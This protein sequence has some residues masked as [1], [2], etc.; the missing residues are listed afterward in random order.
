[1]FFFVQ[2]SLSDAFDFTGKEEPSVTKES[3]INGTLI[4]GACKESL[5]TGKVVNLKEYTAK[6]S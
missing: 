2:L 3:T 6:H 5:D 1:M 4:A